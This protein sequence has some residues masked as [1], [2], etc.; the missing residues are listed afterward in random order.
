MTSIGSWAFGSCSS[1]TSITIPESV[2]S[3]GYAAFDNCRSL[4][5]ITIPESVTSIGECAFAS[6][7]SLTSITYNGTQSQWNKISKA[8]SW[9]NNSAIKTITCTDGVI[10]IN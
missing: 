3:I 9:K 7:F 10:Q 5:S 8:S 6:C 4:T 2:T 1:L